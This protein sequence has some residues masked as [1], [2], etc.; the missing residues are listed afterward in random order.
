M[1]RGIRAAADLKSG[2]VISREDLAILRPCEE[3]TFGADKLDLVLGKR[4]VA[5][6]QK[7]Q[8]LSIEDLE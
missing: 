1:K 2:D 5:N 4:L 6:V 8:G 3:N 7:G